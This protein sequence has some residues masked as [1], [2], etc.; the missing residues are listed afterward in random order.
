[1]DVFL[2]LRVVGN[3]FTEPLPSNGYMGH[4]ILPSIFWTY[5]KCKTITVT[6]RVGPLCCETSRIPYFLDNRLADS[7]KVV[8]LTRPPPFPL[9]E[10]SWYAFL[11]EAESTPGP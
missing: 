8:S 5:K 7:G 10:D 11:L 1:M 3:V 2:L 6:G 4:N 9:Q